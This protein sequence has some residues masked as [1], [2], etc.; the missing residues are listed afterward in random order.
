MCVNGGSTT[1][2]G[3]YQFW[4]DGQRQTRVQVPWN[5]I[6][7]SKASLKSAVLLNQVLVLVLMI[8]LLS[9]HI[10]F[11]SFLQM[12]RKIT[13]LVTIKT[14]LHTAIS[15]YDLALVV[16]SILTVYY[17]S[18]KSTAYIIETNDLMKGLTYN[19][20]TKQSFCWHCT[21]TVTKIPPLALNTH[22][23]YPWARSTL[24]HA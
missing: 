10:W 20:T 16:S 4:A 22:Q 19:K 2:W 11:C 18:Q 17:I 24:P 23:I 7:K 8:C 12:M 15:K 6:F 21:L 1:W 13:Y 3:W 9:S 5:P 14:L